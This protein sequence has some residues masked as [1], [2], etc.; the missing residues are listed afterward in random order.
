MERSGRPDV[1]LRLTGGAGLASAFRRTS[2]HRQL[3][4][5]SPCQSMRRIR[6]LPRVV[7]LLLLPLGALAAGRTA[8]A[9]PSTVETLKNSFWMGEINDSTMAWIAFAA[10]GRGFV[11]QVPQA[12]QADGSWKPEFARASS[13]AGAW[14]VTRKQELCFYPDNREALDL[15]SRPTFRQR[16]LAWHGVIAVRRAYDSL[17]WILASDAQM[18]PLPANTIGR[19]QRN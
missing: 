15:C 5:S 7:P 3:T 14:T 2:M 11:G 10:N 8:P 16:T 12:R 19:T 1:A 18:S 13:A 6:M 9:L 4:S 17:P